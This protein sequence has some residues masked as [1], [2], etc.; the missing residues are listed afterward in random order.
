M[1]TV[2]CTHEMNIS[3]HACACT[4]DHSLSQVSASTSLRAEAVF[5]FVCSSLIDCSA[6]ALPAMERSSGVG[7]CSCRPT[8][9]ISTQNGA[10]FS[11]RV[12]FTT[13]S[14]LGIPRQ[15]LASAA[16]AMANWESRSIPFA[17]LSEKPSYTERLLDPHR[18]RLRPA[19]SNISPAYG[20]PGPQEGTRQ[21]PPHGS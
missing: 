7:C 17:W 4:H 5:L 2:Y 14:C 10:H 19:S 1:E 12:V 13:K 18:S 8:M 6:M 11:F 21:T 16:I 15:G 9:S 20:T 3:W